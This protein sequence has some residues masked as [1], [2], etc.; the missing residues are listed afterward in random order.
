[1]KSI[2][3]FFR[4]KKIILT[5]IT[6]GII[7]I[8]NIFFQA[9]KKAPQA[10]AVA[11]IGDVKE[12]LTLSGK[13]DTQ[14]HAILD[15]GISGKVN[16][17]G[18]KEGDWVEEGQLIA[19]LDKETLEAALRQAWQTFVA[20]KAASDRYYDAR[21]GDTEN[22]SEKV[23]RTALDA[24]QNKAYDSIRI[25]QENLKSAAL[26]SPI[27][28]LVVVAEPS[29]PGIN[30]TT[31][32][33][34]YEIVNPSTVYLKV[35]ADQTEVGSLEEGQKGIIVFDSYPEEQVEGEIGEISFIPARDETGT[36][37]VIKIILRD[38][39]NQ[40]YKYKLGMTADVNFV[41]KERKGVLIIPTKYVKSDEK[42]KYVL[43]GKDKK[44][45]YVKIGIEGNQNIEIKEG[46]SEGEI[47]YD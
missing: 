47:V 1:M 35:T 2:S 43:M 26:Y 6:I 40:D 19:T 7:L 33:S 25:A 17:V 8:G 44:K 30:I 46:L 37:Y 38:I 4:N 5:A 10:S 32:N 13:I 29:L 12:E 16:W 28:G 3:R 42:G 21:S 15:F 11:R 24:T 23:E 34:G 39:D 18:V 45:K 41:I 14:E 9:S 22:Y 27:E 20:A 36:V 31:L